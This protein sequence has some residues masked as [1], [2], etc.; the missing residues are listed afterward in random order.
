MNHCFS[1]LAW[2]T[3]EF[4]V[5]TSEFTNLGIFSSSNKSDMLNEMIVLVT[6]YIRSTFFDA[7]TPNT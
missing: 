5:R 1:K 6:V 3:D 2:L 7:I 4:Y